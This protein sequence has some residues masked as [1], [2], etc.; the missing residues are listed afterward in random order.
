MARKVRTVGRG[1][2]ERQHVTFTGADMAPAMRRGL[3][4]WSAALEAEGGSGFAA[5]TRPGVAICEELAQ[6][7]GD[8]ELKRWARQFLEAREHCRRL[9]DQGDADLAARFA[10]DAGWSLMMVN[11]K[12]NWERD[13]LAG[14]AHRENGGEGRPRDPGV[15]ARNI[16]MAREFEARRA[17]GLGAVTTTQLKVAI[18]KAVGLGRTRSIDA[19]NE[20]LEFLSAKGG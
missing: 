7:A 12:L 20:G 17:A 1:V 6:S 14:R 19:I 13:A 8:D 4:A 3:G 9:L 11:F 5:Q 15:R 2:S 18:G 10:Y 16:R